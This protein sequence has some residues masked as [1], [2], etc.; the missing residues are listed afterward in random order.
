[1]KRIFGVLALTA[2]ILSTPSHTSAAT[3]FSGTW[4]LN[5]SKSKNIGMMSSMQITLTIKQTANELV[6]SEISKFNGQEQKREL[7]Y[8]L[9]GKPSPNNGPMGDPND[10]LT[11]SVGQTLETTWTQEGP[12]AG[13]KTV[14][15]KPDRSLRAERS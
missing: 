3:D 5:V 11:K 10:T 13:T 4:S 14:R 12:V 8:D 9:G 6:I 1:V 2:A 7:H 15:T